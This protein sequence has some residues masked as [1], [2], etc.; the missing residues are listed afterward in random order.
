M[1][2]VE[3]ADAAPAGRAE[4]APAAARLPVFAIIAVAVVAFLVGGAGGSYQG[5]LGEVQKNDNAAYLPATAES[6]KA[7]NDSAEFLKIETIPG[8]LVFQRAGGLTA[9]DDRPRSTRRSP[10]SRRC[11]ASTEP[12]MTPPEFSPDGTAASIYAPLIAK[13]NGKS[14]STAT[15]CPTTRSGSS[16]PRKA[17]LPAGLAVVPGRPGRA[18]RRPS[19][20]P[21][22]AWTARCCWRRAL[23][24]IVI[25][26]W[27]TDRR[28]C[29]SS[30]SSRAV[31][32]LGLSSMVIYFLAKNDVLTLTGQSQGILSVLVLGA[33][34][35]YA[36]L[37]ISR[38][39]EELHNYANRVRR[40]DQGLARSPRRPSSPPASP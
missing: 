19:S 21:S 12:Q 6:T 11:P 22:A 29:G 15:S 28:S 8:F 26:L 10:R 20:A 14:R 2:D 33:G 18:A 35:D 5:K 31:L 25:L 3:I 34:T 36:L 39:R 4:P 1:T 38:Y 17:R 30:R 7:A 24:V 32:A 27:S 9:A 23:V 16:T 37:L 13:Q 40:D